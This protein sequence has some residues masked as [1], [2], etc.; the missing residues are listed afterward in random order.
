MFCLLA[1]LLSNGCFLAAASSLHWAWRGGREKSDGQKEGKRFQQTQ[2][3]MAQNIPVITGQLCSVCSRGCLATVPSLDWAAEIPAFSGCRSCQRCGMAGCQPPEPSLAA[4]SC[5][6][7]SPASWSSV[8]G[9]RSL[10]HKSCFVSS[11]CDGQGGEQGQNGG[12]WMSGML[13]RS[14]T[15]CCRDWLVGESPGGM[16]VLFCTAALQALKLFR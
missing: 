16:L 12:I 13:G 11:P 14:R 6:G 15:H 9:E 7:V 3:Q 10:M 1:C 8:A 4:G 2:L 5:A